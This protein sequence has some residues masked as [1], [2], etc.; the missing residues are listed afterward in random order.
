[1]I[2]FLPG[3]E[4]HS[5]QS[6]SGFLSVFFH[7]GRR[8]KALSVP[9]V[10]GSFPEAHAAALTHSGGTGTA[11]AAGQI[12]R[13]CPLPSAGTHN[14]S[15]IGVALSGVPCGVLPAPHNPD[16]ATWTEHPS[17][18]HGFSGHS[19]PFPA[20]PRGWVIVL[21][22]GAR[23]PR[24]E[25]L[26]AKGVTGN[27]WGTWARCQLPASGAAAI[28]GSPQDAP[29]PE[30]PAPCCV[31]GSAYISHEAPLPPRCAVRA[32]PGRGRYGAEGA[33]P[34]PW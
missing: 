6:H 29:P 18:L 15:Y 10:Q 9:G 24:C 13:L 21:H 31:T 32:A 8:D 34:L 25:L 23:G 33:G 30:R 11:G 20:L 5:P 26:G 17:T 1:M 14:V 7:R 16:Q 3:L 28:L 12:H 19:E 2:C 22:R 27:A 4:Q